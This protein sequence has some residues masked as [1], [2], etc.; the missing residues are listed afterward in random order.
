MSEKKSLDILLKL[1][2]KRNLKSSEV[3]NFLRNNTL[4][5]NALDK[6]GYNALHYAIKSELPEIVKIPFL[7]SASTVCPLPSI[8]LVPEIVTEPV[9]EL[10]YL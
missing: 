5:L 10:E 9:S 7:P 6:N 3:K 8:V 4:D 2:K 1:L